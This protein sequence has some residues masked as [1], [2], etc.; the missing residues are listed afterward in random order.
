MCSGGSMRRWLHD[1]ARHIECA[2]TMW[3]LHVAKGERWTIV[4]DRLEEVWSRRTL[5]FMDVFA[6]SHEKSKVSALDVSATS[7]AALRHLFGTSVSH[8]VRD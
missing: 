2:A 7:A 6:V 4:S 3:S 1:I 5:T 8:L